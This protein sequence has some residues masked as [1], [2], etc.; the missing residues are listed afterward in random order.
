MEH[1]KFCRVATWF[2]GLLLLDQQSALA[3][4]PSVSLSDL[5]LL[6]FSTISFF[7][8]LV[9]LSA[10]GIR[11]LWNSV[12]RDFP[13]LPVLS[14]RG[15]LTGVLLWGL[16]FVVVLTMISGARELMTPG[17]WVKNGLTYRSADQPQETDAKRISVEVAR[18]LKEQTDR[19]TRLQLLGTALREFA[20]QHNSAWPTAEEFRLLPLE[21]TILPG[22]VQ[23]DYLYRPVTNDKSQ[24]AAVHEDVAVVLEP[25]VYGDGQQF[26]LYR[27][28]LV[29]PFRSTP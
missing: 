3:G 16:V 25:D 19:I 18:Q 11:F 13:K 24:P 12:R 20:D 8:L 26:A 23:A 6:R 1:I 29:G 27:S 2:I 15:A 4:M 21:L 7:L 14:F 28:G 5:G 22:D 10:I 17:A 9:V